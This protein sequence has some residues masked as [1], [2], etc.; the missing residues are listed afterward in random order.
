MTDKTK[1]HYGHVDSDNASDV[2][3]PEN[4]EG[5]TIYLI[6]YD[7]DRT[8]TVSAAFYN[9][10]LNTVSEVIHIFIPSDIF[11][12]RIIYG[13]A[14]WLLM[15]RGERRKAGKCMAHMVANNQFPQLRFVGCQHEHPKKYQLR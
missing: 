15:T 3:P 14:L 1:T 11:T 13:E 4:H 8:Y 2:T 12:L 5:T 9:D 10:V 6:L 7:E